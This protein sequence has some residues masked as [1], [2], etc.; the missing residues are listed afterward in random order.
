MTFIIANMVE[1]LIERRRRSLNLPNFVISIIFENFFVV[2]VG[3]VLVVLLLSDGSSTGFK[4]C[5]S[6]WS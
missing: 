5:C 6:S 3:V 4:T 1:N 2:F